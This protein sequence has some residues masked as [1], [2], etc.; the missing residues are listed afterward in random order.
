VELLAYLLCRATVGPAP[1]YVPPL[2]S[3]M[4]GVAVYVSVNVRPPTG[5]LILA[6]QSC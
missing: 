3:T 2:L 4:A 1:V 6:Y 5:C